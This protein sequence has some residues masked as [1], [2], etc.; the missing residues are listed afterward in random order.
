VKTVSEEFNMMKRVLLAGAALMALSG[1]ANALV[2]FSDDF[3]SNPVAPGIT[4]SGWAVTQGSVDGVSGYGGHLQ[5][6]MKGAGGDGGI[7]TLAGFN[8]TTGNVYKVS[9]DY[10]ALSGALQALEV[11]IGGFSAGV[12]NSAVQNSLINVSFLFSVS[13]DISAAALAFTGFGLTPSNDGLLLDNVLLEQVTPVPL[14][15]AAVLLATGL[16]GIGALGRK[17]K[18]T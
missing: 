18:S 13:S 3:N 7:K 4:P 2:L 5:I 10:G 15:P 1:A 14:P 12:F 9:F 16:M 17:R 11:S 6:D 8:L